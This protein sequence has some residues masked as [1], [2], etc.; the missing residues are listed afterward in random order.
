MWALLRLGRATFLFG[1]IFLSYILQLWL[2][3][4]FG[5]ERM[6]ERWKGVH[7]KNAKRLYYGMV[8]LRG[9]F[10]K[11]G[12]ILSVMGTFLPRVYAVELEKLQDRVPPQPFDVIEDAITESLGQPLAALYATFEEQ[13]LAAASLGQV[14]R[15]T[16]RTGEEVAV[17]VLYPQIAT[18]IAIDLVVMG[19][20]IR[21]LK[22]WF[23]GKIL[24]G[25]R[26]QLRDLLAHETDYRHE[27]RCMK[28][29]ADNFA[30]HSDV[31]FPQSFAEL[32]SERV[33][34]MTFM[35]GV[36]ISR[37][38][39]LE[40]MGLEP[41][42]VARVLV[43]AFYKQLFVD[44]FFHAD[45]HPGNFLVQKGDHGKPRVV[46]LD[47]GAATECPRNLIDG[48]LDVLK[49]MFARDDGT[50]LRGIHTM[51]FVSADGN[52]ELL[53]RTVKIYFQ[54]L[55][56]LDIKDFGRIRPEAAASLADP[57]LQRDELRELMQSVAYPEGW[58]YVERAVIIMFGLAAQ[59]APK[60]NTF[61][62]GFPYVMRLMASRQ[63]E[64][65]AAAAE[66][67][68]AQKA[69]LASSVSGSHAA[70]SAP[71]ASATA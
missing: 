23:P 42:A 34:T 52:V 56:A 5:A 67:A 19:W 8:T 13:S 51:G 55:L 27:A 59:L 24:D 26:E 32:S 38:A 57:G 58:F 69:R 7:A 29:M 37:K 28:R 9:V 46:V 25:V 66:A 62:I 31:L 53:E 36:K 3:R 6:R 54:K 47:F 20:A 17:K 45:P 39:E 40:A 68:A 1:R 14:H 15:A 44:G 4:L 18:I 64:A 30:G 2:V 63:A 71:A 61:Q 41:D 16:L 60:L 33:L 35:P 43:E 49:G 12:Q 22:H 50:V 11:L 48:M 65:D 70:V 21:V 10:I